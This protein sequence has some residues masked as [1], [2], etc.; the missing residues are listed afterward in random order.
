MSLM[1]CDGDIENYIAVAKKG[2]IWHH[3][4]AVESPG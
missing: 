3:E 1:E 2:R 4:L